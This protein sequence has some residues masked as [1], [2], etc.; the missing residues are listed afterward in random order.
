MSAFFGL[1][2]KLPPGLAKP[3][4]EV[5]GALLLLNK[6]G[7]VTVGVKLL[8]PQA[9]GKAGAAEAGAA[10]GA[11]IWGKLL[12]GVRLAGR[13]LVIDLILRQVLK[14]IGGGRRPPQPL[15]KPLRGADPPPPAESAETQAPSPPD[16]RTPR[17]Q[18]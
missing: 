10:A 16:P 8:G 13:A 11:G 1:I 5:A 6:L 18:T 12:P 15:D 14:T 7:V 4:F 2:A 9:A 3:L 17:Q